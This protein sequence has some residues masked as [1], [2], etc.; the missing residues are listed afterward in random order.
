MSDDAT[1]SVAQAFAD[2]ARRHR[3][4]IESGRAARL[5]VE[6]R[7]SHDG[8]VHTRPARVGTRPVA[9]GEAG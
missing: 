7:I 5:L 2:E 4:A 1:E 8:V 3:E 6:V 9:P